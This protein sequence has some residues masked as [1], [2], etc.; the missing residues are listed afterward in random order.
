MTVTMEVFSGSPPCQ[1]CI[2]SLK[3]ADE[4]TE[5]YKDGLQVTKLVGKEASAKFDEYNLSC[6]PAIVI[7]G[8]IRIE[9]ICPSHAT[10]DAALQEG[11]LS[12]K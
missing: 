8:K 7:N 12:V 11:G 9:G 4:Y 10:L 5:K 1:D 6:T 2:E 3:L